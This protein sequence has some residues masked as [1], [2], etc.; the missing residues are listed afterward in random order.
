[1]SQIG[2]GIQVPPNSSKI[3]EQWGL[4]EAVVSRAVQPREIVI[5]SYRDGNI[6][7]KET[8]DPA[9]QQ[10]Y[11]APYLVI[12]RAELLKT[13]VG[14]AREVGVTIVLGSVIESIDFAKASILFEDKKT[15]EADLIIGADG[16]RSFCRDA[17][18]GY[19]D[20]P[21]HSGDIVFRIL[22]PVEKVRE[23]AELIDLLDP[24]A[25]HTWLGPDAHALA[26]TLKAEGLLNV[27][28]IRPDYPG[29]EATFGPQQADMDHI[30][31]SIKQWDRRFKKLLGHAQQASKWILVKC[32]DLPSWIHPA[33]KFTLLGD[34]A[35]AMLPYL[36]QGA[37]QAIEDAAI[38][39]G[40]LLRLE[41]RSQIPDILSI[42]ERLRRPRAMQVKRQ[43]LATRNINGMADGAKQRERDRQLLEHQPFDGYPNPLADPVFSEWLFGYTA[44]EEVE[45]AWITYKKGEWP[46]TSGMWDIMLHT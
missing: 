38:L 6:L 15:L 8:L 46:L 16:E 36:A 20:P 35:H 40:L 31:G 37:A 12:H 4:L 25:V 3:L 1:M 41:H 7:S 26:Y 13:L 44:T 42:Y 45:K 11:G 43:S 9:M 22:I 5:H 10:A 14:K 28:L 34:S 18:L 23:D 29:V 32:T 24:P 39:S 33:G 2:A 17:L 21:Q 19:P 27:V 30:R